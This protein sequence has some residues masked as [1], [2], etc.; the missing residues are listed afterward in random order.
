MPRQAT[1]E[2]MRLQSEIS[3]E[4]DRDA[5]E[6]ATMVFGETKDQPDVVSVPNER[7]DEVYRQAYL[8]EDRQ[9]LQ[10][11]AQRDPQ[12][13]LKVAERI[14]VQK[15]PAPLPGMASQTPPTGAFAKQASTPPPVAVP[16]APV[17]PPVL[18]VAPVQAVPAPMPIQSPPPVVLGPNGQPLPPSGLV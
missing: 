17:L 3:S 6:I 9:W 15:P 12:Q 18:P 5:P 7:V 11:E 13:F 8:R 14:G 1:N 16:P 2:I 10:A 4:I